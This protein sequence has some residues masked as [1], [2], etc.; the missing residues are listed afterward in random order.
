M[1]SQEI[2]FPKKLSE[3]NFDFLDEIKSLDCF[4]IVNE[5]ADLKCLE[6]SRLQKWL[7]F[8]NFLI[9]GTGGSCLGGQCIHAISDD[10]KL[11]NKIKFISNLDPNTLEKI[12][13]NT[14]FSKTGIL[15]ISK[16]GET[17]ETISQLLLMITQLKRNSKHII[18]PESVIIITEDKQS[19][20]KQIASEFSFLC[21]DHPKTIGG[22]FSVFSI[23][24][25]LPALMCGIDP[26]KIRSGGK[27][28]L[29]NFDTV[30]SGSTFIV[31]S[32]K[33][34]LTQH[35]SFVYSDRL[36]FFAAWLAQLYA[37]SSGKNGNGITPLT[38]TGSVDQHSQLQLYLDG[39]NDKCFTFF[40]EEFNNVLAIDNSDYIPKP[41]RY[42]QNKKVSEIFNA[43]YEATIT[44]ILEKNRNIRK[45]KIP[46]F[47][48]E[49]IGSLF[50]HFMLEAICICKLI[51]VNPFDQPAVEHGKI[52]TKKLLSNI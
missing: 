36:S 50:M 2:L 17:L 24:G 19:S 39:A 44:S 46:Q 48:P 16:S 32:F 10:D 27:E 33:N 38:A 1:F 47:T 9:L 43:Q 49:I 15:C 28:I 30:K 25:M 52:I 5:R 42:L 13:A 35:V 20:L 3:F 41:F 14:D 29:N 45:I 12:I 37:E 7:Q 8:D 22:R 11:K 40:I 51:G 26:I 34:I 23:V 4:S 31:Q 6:N 21:L 18:P